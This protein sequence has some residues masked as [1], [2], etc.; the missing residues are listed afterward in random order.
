MS[1]SFSALKT[2]S[3]VNARQASQPSA[4]QALTPNALAMLATISAQGSFAKAAHALGLVPSALTYRVRQL[5]EA[6]DVLL[7][8]RSARQ[9]VPTPAGAELVAEGQRI[10]RELDAVA[11]RVRR[12]A[13][14]WEPQL[15]IAVD[16]I[17]SPN[18]MMELAEQFFALKSPTRIKLR[19]ETLSGTLESLTSGQSDLA[20]GVVPD[21]SMLTGMQSKPLGHISM[22]FAVAPHH[23]LANA[24]EP[25]EDALLAQHRVV[26]VADTVQR[27]RGITVGLL[28]GQDV[29]TVASMGAKLDA[30]M[31]GLGCG[32]VPECMARPYVETGRLVV[33]TIRHPR[34]GQ[35]VAYAWRAERTDRGGVGKALAW[36]LK[37]LESP[38][39][40]VALLE[41]R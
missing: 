9:A 8:D 40:R 27:G 33:K 31:R 18:V 38:V 20:V 35:R 32:S 2:P 3:K 36:W 4:A 7:F 34:V 28:G 17:V 1:K 15:T 5:E 25:L 10:M 22:V 19:D 13:T 39:T 24:P 29:F 26:A 11:N 37:A 21:A 6:L 14:G 23:P 41:R 30:Q 16:S 12:V